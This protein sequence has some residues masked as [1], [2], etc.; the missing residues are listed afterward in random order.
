[1]RWGK[2]FAL[3]VRRQT[4]V[5]THKRGDHG[6]SRLDGGKGLYYELVDYDNV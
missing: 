5:R 3:G 2:N 1:M 4:S 6:Q